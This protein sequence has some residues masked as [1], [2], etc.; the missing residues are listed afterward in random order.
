L[1]VYYLQRF[2]QVEEIIREKIEESSNGNENIFFEDINNEFESN[3]N[4]TY[5]GEKT[6][7]IFDCKM[8]RNSIHS[9]TVIAFFVFERF[10]LKK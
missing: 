10:F 4:D 9:I 6:E 7:D 3:V 2:V 5:G 8:Y 1:F